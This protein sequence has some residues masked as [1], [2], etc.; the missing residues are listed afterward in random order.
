MKL[1]PLRE[2]LAGP[3]RKASLVLLGAVSFVLLIAC[4][5][6]ANLLLTR[7]TE[8]RK[9]LV[10]RAALGA[11]RARLMQQLITESVLLTGLSAAAGM[12]VAHWAVKLSTVAQPAQL[13]AQA[14]VS[15]LPRSLGPRVPTHLQP[16]L[17]HPARAYAASCR[18][19][20]AR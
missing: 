15:S 17:Y 10:L 13:T 3:V 4:A 5:N 6:V 12:L 2:Q 16:L 7:I 14:D 8:R 18:C 1:I 11:S 19:C 20:A 9:E